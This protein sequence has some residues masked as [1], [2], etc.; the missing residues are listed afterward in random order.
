MVIKINSYINYGVCTA[1]IL[2]ASWF[3][4][5]EE[6]MFPNLSLLCITIHAWCIVVNPKLFDFVDIELQVVAPFD[7]T[8][9]MSLLVWANCA[10]LALLHFM[11]LGS[12]TFLPEIAN[13]AWFYWKHWYYI[14][15]WLLQEYVQMIRWLRHNN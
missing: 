2:C 3:N 13:K 4:I 9:N 8:L 14:D 12:V 10:I 6:S 1:H 7:H 15:L 5:G 11:V